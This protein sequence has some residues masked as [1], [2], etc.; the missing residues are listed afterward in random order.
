MSRRIPGVT[1]AEVVVPY[2][3]NEQML[4]TARRAVRHARSEFER[5]EALVDALEDP[6]G[7]GLRYEPVST[8]TAQATIE[9]G[10]G[11]CYSLAS[12]LV[13]LARG[14]GMRAY[15]VDAS[16]WQNEVRRDPAAIVSAGHM[17]AAVRTDRGLTVLDFN[18]VFSRRHTFRLIDDVEAL[19]HFYNNRGYELIHDAAALGRPIPW[20]EAAIHFE[21]ATRLDPDLAGAWNNLGIAYA[22]RGRD[23]EA[24]RH[25]R[26]AIARDPAAAEAHNNMGS[27]LLRRGDLAGA[28]ASFDAAVQHDRRNPYHH[29][30]RAL[31]LYRSGE[32]AG[33][34]RSL[35]RAL[36]LDTTYGEP[37]ELLAQIYRSLGRTE[38]A[39]RLLAGSP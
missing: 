37:R 34:A 20:G 17:S 35:E 12:L 3:V 33:A 21:H 36:D 24:L 8:A 19:A 26:E 18:G 10:E 4:S 14:L 27:L 9:G 39:D 31:A 11:N 22:R 32:L 7:F 1:Q 16:R 5:V 28:L 29:Y 30:H 13:G 2:E 38:A 25:Y 23:D 6:D 15:Y